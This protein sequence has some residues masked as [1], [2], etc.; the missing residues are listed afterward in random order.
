VESGSCVRKTDVKMVEV[1]KGRS[2]SLCAVSVS[3]VANL[4]REVKSGPIVEV[5][6]TVIESISSVAIRTV[7]QRWSS[8]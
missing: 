3:S 6:A 8:S 2:P 1:S 7:P 4:E 5:E